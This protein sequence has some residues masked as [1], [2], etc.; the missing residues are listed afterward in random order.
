M[1]QLLPVSLCLV[2]L[3]CAAPIP[4]GPGARLDDA[5]TTQVARITRDGRTTAIRGTLFRPDDLHPLRIQRLL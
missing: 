2:G 5:S 4:E 3:A 1:K